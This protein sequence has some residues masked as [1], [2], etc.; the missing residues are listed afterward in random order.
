MLMV[1][2]AVLAAISLA[3]CASSSNLL[4]EAEIKGMR[5]DRVDVSFKIDAVI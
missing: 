5:I 1:L 3:A 2:S 4:S